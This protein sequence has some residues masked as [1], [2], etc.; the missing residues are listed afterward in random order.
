[1]VRATVFAFRFGA[2]ALFTLHRFWL[3]RFKRQFR[4]NLPHEFS[5][6]DPQNAGY[7]HQGIY[8]IPL[9]AALQLG[10]INRRKTSKA[11]KLT[12]R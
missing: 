8:R 12:L 9:N 3:F 1:M 11:S 10:N 6:V 2:L 4:F 5:K 7:L